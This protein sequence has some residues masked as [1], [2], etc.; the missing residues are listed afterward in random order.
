MLN[1]GDCVLV[2]NLSER[3]SPGKKRTYWEDKFIPLF[4]VYLQKVLFTKLSPRNQMDDRGPYIVLFCC[5][6]TTWNLILHRNT[7]KTNL[8]KIPVHAIE[9]HA[10][11]MSKILGEGESRQHRHLNII[12]AK[13]L[14]IVTR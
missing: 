9:L 10:Q 13:R 4:V 5:H 12:F 6:A 3:G 14:I 11:I 1:P 7:A 2:R 8:H